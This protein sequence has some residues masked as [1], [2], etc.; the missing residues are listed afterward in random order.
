MNDDGRAL[1]TELVRLRLWATPRLEA[2]GAWFEPL[3]DGM[4]LTLVAIPAGSFWMGSPRGE[5]GRSDNEGPQHRVNLDGFWMGQTPITQ[6]QWRRV[7]GTNPSQFQGLRVDC[8]Q[9]PVE[10]VIWN[11][12]MAFCDKL[13]QRTG[14][15]YSLPSEA[16]WE[17][18]CRA[19]TSSPFHF[20]G[21]LISELANFDATQGY[22]EA[23]PGGRR[24][25][26]SAS[27]LFPA[28]GWGLHDLHG[29]VWEWCLNAWHDFYRRAPDDGRARVSEDSQEARRL[30]RGGS[31]NNF[32]RYCR[33]A[34]R[35]HYQ[36]VNANNFVGFRVV[37]LPQGPSLNP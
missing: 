22:G 24:G 6:A 33:S 17:Y 26:T 23:P 28:N 11:D 4:A 25:V 32:P 5:E 1:R 9:R 13:S 30:L 14:R 10:Q 16:Q 36:S 3:G 34:Y 21:T 19:G 20:G 37:C 29:N 2:P 18:A 31:W 12:A 15:F 8:E 27:G 35:N 7:M